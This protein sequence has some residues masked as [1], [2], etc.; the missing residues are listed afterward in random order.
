MF[1]ELNQQHTAFIGRM[2]F[3]FQHTRIQICTP[4]WPEELLKNYYSLSILIHINGTAAMVRLFYSI[5]NSILN[6]HEQA[7]KQAFRFSNHFVVS[8]I[9]CVA[10]G[11]VEFIT[12]NYSFG[13]MMKMMMMMLSLHLNPSNQPANWL[14]SSELAIHIQLDWYTFY[15]IYVFST[16]LFIA[17][18]MLL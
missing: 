14:V 2:E 18:F 4:G 5:W 15:I 12:S 9:F 16:S 3:G 11:R 17:L 6:E 8:S 10:C 13:Q 1:I 7:G